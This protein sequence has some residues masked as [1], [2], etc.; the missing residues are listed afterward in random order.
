MQFVKHSECFK[1]SYI[2]CQQIITTST[3]SFRM[4]QKTRFSEMSMAHQHSFAFQLRLWQ[5]AHWLLH[6]LNLQSLP[7]RAC[8]SRCNRHELCAS[9]EK[10]RPLGGSWHG[11]WDLL[12][13][14]HLCHWHLHLHLHRLH[15]ASTTLLMS[16]FLRKVYNVMEFGRQ[17]LRHRNLIQSWNPKCNLIC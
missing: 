1:C 9:G 11:T 4:Q 7:P 14:L 5:I 8:S 10:V 16:R 6:C 12:L 13:I 17:N 3:Y 2:V 15:D